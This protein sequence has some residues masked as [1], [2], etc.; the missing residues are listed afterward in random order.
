MAS[1]EQIERGAARRTQILAFIRQYSQEHG[2]SPTIRE[3][4]AGVGLRSPRGV[5]LHLQRMIE[6]G[7]LTMRPG[8]HRAISLR[9]VG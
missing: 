5:Q 4:A 2:Y 7:Q 6:D 3:I 9:G 8:G 1:G